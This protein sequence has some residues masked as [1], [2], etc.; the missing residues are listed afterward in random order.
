MFSLVVLSTVLA[1]AAAGAPWVAPVAYE[2]Y[3]AVP[4]VV[5]QKEIAYQKNIIEEPTITHVGNIEKK[6]PTGYSYQKFT[7]YHN[8][9][10]AQDVY[11]P[12][13]RKT[14]V[15]TP[16]EN[17]VYQAPAVAAPVL[18]Y[19][20]PSLTYAAAPLTKAAY[21]NAAPSLTYA[22]APLTKAAYINAVPALNYAAP[23]LTYGTP[24][25]KKAYIDAVPALSYAPLAKSV[26][27]HGLPAVYDSPAI[28]S[29]Y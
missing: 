24:L 19:A 15:E 2:H 17:I 9:P 5:A 3:A 28:F 29:K 25:L 26:Y 16:V 4:T 21:I 7:Q 23:A 18:T 6:I 22:A 27:S 20:A 14:L 13:V 10:V 8:K 1:V 12:A 11:A